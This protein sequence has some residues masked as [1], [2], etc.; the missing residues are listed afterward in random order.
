MFVSIQPMRIQMPVRFDQGPERDES[1]FPKWTLSLPKAQIPYVMHGP[2]VTKRPSARQ[3]LS[4][5]SVG[6]AQAQ[7][8]PEQPPISFGPAHNTA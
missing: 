2:S 8:R 7:G 1:G 4:M 6:A 3:E 5:A